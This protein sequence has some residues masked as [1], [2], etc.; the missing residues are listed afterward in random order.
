VIEQPQCSD[1]TSNAFDAIDACMHCGLCIESCPTY[2]ATG[3]ESDSPRGRLQLMRAVHEQRLTTEDIQP[4]LERC[5]QC[6][7]CESSCPSNVDYSGL[8]HDN[9]KKNKSLVA[10]VMA[11][12]ALSNLAGF[13]LQISSR[14]GLHRVIRRLPQHKFSRALMLT[15]DNTKRFSAKQKIH[16]AHGDLR[17]KVALQLGCIER[18]INGD[19]IDDL[20]AVF[21]H[22]GFELHIVEQESC[23]GAIHY[24]T[25]DTTT[26][27]AMAKECA[28]SFGKFDFVVSLSAGCS[29]HLQQQSGKNT[30][31]DPLIFL[32]TQG[33][34]SRLKAVKAK[35]AWMVPCHLK[36]LQDNWQQVGAML[37]DIPQLNLIEFNDSDLCCGAGGA[38]MITKPQL[39]SAMG[40]AKAHC[41]NDA[42]PQRI[43]SSNSGCRMQVDAHLRFIGS[44]QRSEHPLRILALALGVDEH[45]KRR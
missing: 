11:N 34:R 15:P 33:L 25:G 6:H 14:L 18:Q 38:A 13:M 37:S 26:G 31:Y 45:I 43:L 8:L 16:P 42:Q 17:A 4:A 24:H 27:T 3:I 30:F 5:V 9:L 21:T 22:Q 32:A 36:H 12:K 23:C 29:A 44:G 41:L 28:S 40:D 1:S 7:A 39:S 19:V 35:V 10:S 2:R 20:I